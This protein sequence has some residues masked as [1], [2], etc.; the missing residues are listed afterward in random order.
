MAKTKLEDE[1]KKLLP[2]S[3]G[4]V[5][6]L[7]QKALSKPDLT[8]FEKLSKQRH[9]QRNWLFV[10]SMFWLSISLIFLF[11]LISVNSYT[12]FTKGEGFSLFGQYELEVL[13]ISVF[14]Q[15]VGIIAIIAKS[16]W[17]EA[18][19]SEMLKTEYL[20]KHRD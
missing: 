20:Q 3:E 12:K 9:S 18:P 4:F 10:L 6:E 15:L 16:L 11:V 7:E 5:E 13:S 8:V 14:G 1:I 19:F 17:D 2:Q